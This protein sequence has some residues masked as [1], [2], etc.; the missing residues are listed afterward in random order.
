[1]LYELAEGPPEPG[2]L[3]E[4]VFMLIALRRQEIE[5][6]KS[7]LLVTTMVCVAAKEPNAIDKAMTNLHNAMFPFAAKGGT[8]EKEA[9]KILKEWAEQR[10]FKVKPLWG[11][12]E[13]K[14]FRSRIT[15]GAAR[16]KAIEGSR[17]KL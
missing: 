9:K 14:R 8:K 5:Y 17:R 12:N 7:K 4:S 13:P 1:M 10:A 15:E 6:E 3:L 11:A 16:V 2:S